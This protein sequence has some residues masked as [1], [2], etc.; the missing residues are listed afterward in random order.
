MIT[1]SVSLFT[2]VTKVVFAV[3][4]KKKKNK[5]IKVDVSKVNPIPSSEYTHKYSKKNKMQG[6]NY[7]GSSINPGCLQSDLPLH[8]TGLEI[9]FLVL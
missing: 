6:I 5:N 2:D 3:T 1:L 4:E 7:C 8:L 9:R